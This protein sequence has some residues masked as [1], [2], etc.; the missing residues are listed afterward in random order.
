M[1]P[2]DNTT[3]HETRTTACSVARSMCSASHDLLGG[4]AHAA[5]GPSRGRLGIRIEEIRT[6]TTIESELFVAAQKH[7]NRHRAEIEAST[8]CGCFFCFRTFPH[9]EINAWIDA[10]QTALCPA[11]GVDSVIG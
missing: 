11:C 2:Q 3:S 6:M 10:S 5:R 1:K 7:A 4:H 9:T 8:R